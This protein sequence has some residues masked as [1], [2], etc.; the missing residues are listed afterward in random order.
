MS[1]S[2]WSWNTTVIQTTMCFKPGNNMPKGFSDINLDKMWE[3]VLFRHISMFKHVR[4]WLVLVS[5]FG[6]FFSQEINLE[7]YKGVHCY[8][9]HGPE[10]FWRLVCAFQCIEIKETF[11]LYSNPT[12]LDLS[13][14]CSKELRILITVFQHFSRWPLW[15]EV[16]VQSNT[17]KIKY[18]QN[19]FEPFK[20]NNQCLE[21]L[22]IQIPCVSII[23]FPINVTY[24]KHKSWQTVTNVLSHSFLR[25]VGGLAKVSLIFFSNWGAFTP[26]KLT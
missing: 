1:N 20:S 10:N 2:T 11:G 22:V 4:M 18:F 5:L 8:P 16:T 24:K 14:K 3:I 25:T 21:I 7:S 15:C 17:A 9:M 23:R 6:W 19:T 12:Q 13:Q 26:L